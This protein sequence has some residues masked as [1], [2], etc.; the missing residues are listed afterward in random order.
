MIE[1]LEVIRKN[2][3]L[4]MYKEFSAKQYERNG[5]DDK[6]KLQQPISLQISERVCF[7]CFASF[8][9]VPIDFFLFVCRE[10]MFFRTK[11]VDTNWKRSFHCDWYVVRN[12]I[13]PQ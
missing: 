10:S 8:C 13:A 5:E 12:S 4:F 9:N 6:M 3:S 2:A 1:K 7:F 11:T